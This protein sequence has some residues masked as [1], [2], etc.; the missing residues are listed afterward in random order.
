MT[1]EDDKA[2]KTGKLPIEQANKVNKML[3]DEENDPPPTKTVEVVNKL[4][5]KK[6]NE[7]TGVLLKHKPIERK[8]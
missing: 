8:D 2:G 4:R 6:K 7:T 1:E 5:E 3:K